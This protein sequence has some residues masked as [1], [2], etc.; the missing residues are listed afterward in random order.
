[1]LKKWSMLTLF[2]IFVMVLWIELQAV[3]QIIGLELRGES[4]RLRE[5]QRQRNEGASPNM[6]DF[7]DAFACAA[8]EGFAAGRS[9]FGVCL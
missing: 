5:S 8:D 4:I 3:R 7:R 9:L 1:M 2:P 6:T